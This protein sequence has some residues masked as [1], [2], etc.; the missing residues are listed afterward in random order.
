VGTPASYRISVPGSTQEFGQAL[1]TFAYGTSTLCG[2]PFNTI[3][4][5]TFVPTAAPTT[6]A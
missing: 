5:A 3:Q 1:V 6:P 2:G 4:L